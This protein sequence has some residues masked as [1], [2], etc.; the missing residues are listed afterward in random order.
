MDCER[1]LGLL[2]ASPDFVLGIQTDGTIEFANRRLRELTGDGIV[3]THMLKFIAPR[4]YRLVLR[5]FQK[6]LDGFHTPAYEIEIV[7]AHGRHVWVEVNAGLQ[8][9]ATGRILA[10]VAVLRETT[11]RHAQIERLRLLAQTVMSVQEAVAI[12]DAHGHLT[13]VNHAFVTTFGYTPNEAQALKFN[14]LVSPANPR[15][16][17]RELY[18]ATRQGHWDGELQMRRRCGSDFPAH[19]TTSQVRDERGRPVASVGVCRDITQQRAD[20]ARIAAMNA[21]LQVM[22]ARLE[23]QNVELQNL[24]EFRANMIALVAHDLKSPLSSI[25]GYTSMLL[26]GEIPPEMSRNTLRRIVDLVGN[27]TALVGGLLDM[28]RVEDSN[29]PLEVVPTEP[30][31]VVERAVRSTVQCE[32]MHEVRIEGTFPTVAAHERLLYQILVN[33]LSNAVKYS[34]Q[35]GT[36]TVRGIPECDSLILQ[37]SDTGLGIPQEMLE[38]VFEPYQR[39][40]RPSIRQITGSGLG[41][42]LVRTFVEIQG[43]QVWAE[44]REGEGSTFSFTLPQAAPVAPDLMGASSN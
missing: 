41:L 32:S 27:T 17:R 6:T 31:P 44:S 25:K 1:A 9:D 28:K 3:G 8:R 35:G 22:N 12:A 11:R 30:L 20:G 21:E 13:F 40:D 2:E 15:G 26:G 29:L 19:L 4:Y 18:N 43:G 36:I 7:S 5:N 10:V 34:P 16:V 14:Q 38:E 37:V 33:L 39:C 24:N 42:N 23:Q